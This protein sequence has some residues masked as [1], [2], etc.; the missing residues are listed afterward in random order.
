[1]KRL[2]AVEALGCAT[3]ICADKTGT[4]TRNE[5]TVKEVVSDVWRTYTAVLRSFCVPHCSV[6]CVAGGMLPSWSGVCQTSLADGSGSCAGGHVHAG[7]GRESNLNK[8]AILGLPP[9]VA[10]E[11]T[12][13]RLCG[14]ESTT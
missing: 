4:L 5:M 7:R 14:V 6:D 1:M 2:P 9:P 13:A 3:V 11:P 10:E 8:I 12:S